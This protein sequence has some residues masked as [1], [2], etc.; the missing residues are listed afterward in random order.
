MT[1]SEQQ[2]WSDRGPAILAST[3]IFC[4]LG[5]FILCWRIAYAIRCKRKLL[6]SDFLLITASVSHLLI[7][8]K[9]AEDFANEYEFRH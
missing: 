1:D 4:T 2:E 6:V 8:H 9:K 7:R 3:Y 5:V